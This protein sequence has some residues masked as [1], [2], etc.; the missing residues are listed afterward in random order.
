MAVG[1]TRAVTVLASGDAQAG[2]ARL[3]R[4]PWTQLGATLDAANVDIGAGARFGASVALS[5]DGAVLAVGHVYAWEWR[6][7]WVPRRTAGLERVGGEEVNVGRAIALSANGAV[8]ALGSY[9]NDGSSG[10]DC[11]DRGVVRVYEWRGDAA[12]CAQ[13][14]DD[15]DPPC[16]A[17]RGDAIDGAAPYD[18][19]GRSVAL[20]A[21]GLVVAGG[22]PG[23][24]TGGFR[25][26]ASFTDNPELVGEYRLFPYS[27]DKTGAV[28]SDPLVG[29]YERSEDD[30]SEVRVYVAAL[31]TND[32]WDMWSVQKR[33]FAG[34]DYADALALHNAGTGHVDYSSGYDFTASPW[35]PIGTASHPM[36]AMRAYQAF[37]DG[38]R[39]PAQMQADNSPTETTPAADAAGHA[40][41]LAWDGAARR[42]ADVDGTRASPDG[43]G[44]ASASPSP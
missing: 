16:W 32:G 11:C 30:G 6:G 25:V 21:D 24:D 8:L 38:R 15:R 39:H 7:R 35:Q 43:A 41:V 31:F 29:L 20:S 17:L 19:F 10:G 5:A 28:V 18:N 23:H 27:F 13:I 40:R 33:T 12:G 34:A 36:E 4:T 2:H 37:A 22:A 42:G 3:P 44:T 14:G 9:R 1:A 26:P